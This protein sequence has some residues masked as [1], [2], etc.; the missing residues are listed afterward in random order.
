MVQFSAAKPV[1]K[2]F[3]P[4]VRNLAGEVLLKEWLKDMFNQ[5]VAVDTPSAWLKFRSHMYPALRHPDCICL[6]E[7]MVI[8]V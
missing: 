6:H 5:F 8:S 3:E 4:T 1:L 7:S 2:K